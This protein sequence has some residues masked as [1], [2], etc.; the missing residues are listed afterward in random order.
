MMN[1]H[2]ALKLNG[3]G[4]QVCS[5]RGFGLNLGF[6]LNQGR[7]QTAATGIHVNFI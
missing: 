7:G 2:L 6:G 4:G 1:I 5:K 3:V